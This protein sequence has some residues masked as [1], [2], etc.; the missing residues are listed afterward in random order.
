LGLFSRCSSLYGAVS[1]DIICDS[2]KN[3]HQDENTE[4]AV[5]VTSAIKR[6]LDQSVSGAALGF[7][8]TQLAT[9]HGKGVRRIFPEGD[10]WIH[11]TDFGYFAYQQPYIRL[12]MQAFDEATRRNFFWGYKPKAGDVLIDVGA[13]VGE[14]TLTFSRAVGERGKV[15]CIEAHPRTYRCLKALVRYNRLTNVI[16][17]Q[18][19]VTEPSRADATIEDS[20]DY[21]SNR[22][23]NAKGIQV[24]ATTVDAIRR[25]L[26]LERVNFLKLNI[27]GAERL[28]IR[29]MAETLKYADVL[30]VC[31]HDFLADEKR[32]ESYR[33]KSVVREFLQQHGLRVVDRSEPGSPPYVNDQVWAYNQRVMPAVG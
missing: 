26:G 9:S 1:I 15:I 12:D 13:G 19:A 10:L 24:S 11:E 7:A 30:C 8:A 17:V 6:L 31:C 27:E 23:G 28:T 33:T 4:I 25:K 5:T 32:D 22:L 2:K 29:G 3:F 16:T 20:A 21:L 14:E 18:Q